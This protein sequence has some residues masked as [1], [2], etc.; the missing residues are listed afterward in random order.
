MLTAQVCCVCMH[1]VQI[2]LKCLVCSWGRELQSECESGEVVDPGGA[3]QS[4]DTEPGLLAPL[5]G[6]QTL[7]SRKNTQFKGTNMPEHLNSLK[8]VSNLH[9]LHLLISLQAMQ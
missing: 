7:H 1:T 8:T 9:F 4:P 5:P 3:A 6:H 2:Q